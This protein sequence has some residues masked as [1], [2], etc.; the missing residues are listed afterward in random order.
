M[1]INIVF[2]ESYSKLIF[3]SR[4]EFFSFVG[5]KLS[6][7]WWEK[8]FCDWQYFF[9]FL[10]LQWEQDFCWRK[11]KVHSIK[12]GPFHFPLGMQSKESDQELLQ[13]GIWCDHFILLNYRKIC[14]FKDVIVVLIVIWPFYSVEFLQSVSRI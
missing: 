10:A 11:C 13:R 4:C 1:I 5:F 14:L 3:T 8:K 9:H 6:T 2:L 12:K 7:R